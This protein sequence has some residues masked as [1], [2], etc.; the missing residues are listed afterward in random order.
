MPARRPTSFTPI[1]VSA[2]RS[3]VE[4][5]G[6]PASCS[7]RQPRHAPRPFNVV[8]LI[9]A[10]VEHA[11][12]VHPPL[13]VLAAIEPGCPDVFADRQ[14]HRPAGAVDF[15]RDLR[16]ARRCADNHDAAV[17]EPAGIAVLLR[18]ELRDRA[19]H[20]LGEGRDAGNVAGAGSEH[21]RAASPVALIGA[22]EVSRLGRAHR[23][24]GRVGPYRRGDRLRVVRKEVDNLGQRS[25]AVGIV[26]LVVV[27][28]QPAL[29]VGRQQVQRIPALGAPAMRHLAA[30]EHH[31]I[32]RPLREATTHGEAGVAGPDDHRGDGANGV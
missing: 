21:E 6:V 5:S 23:C 31:V 10:L 32:N 2:L 9:V 12:G 15:V 19:R 25:V 24:H 29:P 26:A 3:S 20:P 16:A 27:S 4:R 11:G 30:L 18:R 22:H 7:D 17:G 8:D 13:Q 1:A 14:D 28:R